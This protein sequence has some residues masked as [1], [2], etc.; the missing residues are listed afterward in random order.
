MSKIEE[1]AI[2]ADSWAE[3]SREKQVGNSSGYELLEDLKLMSE[4]RS[5]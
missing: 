3:Q 2:E 4:L 5:K 1:Q